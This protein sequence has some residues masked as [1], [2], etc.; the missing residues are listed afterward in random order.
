MLNLILATV[1]SFVAAIV[2][3]L[4]I[5]GSIHYALGEFFPAFEF[6]YAQCTVAVLLWSLLKLSKREVDSHEGDA[7]DLIWD[8]LMFDIMRALMIAG[9]T[10]TLAQIF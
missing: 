7:Y 9:M 10:F 2:G 6:T 4:A 1:V 8:S 5:G 3:G